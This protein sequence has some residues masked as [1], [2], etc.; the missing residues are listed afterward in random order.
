[1]G[2]LD[3]VQEG[4]LGLMKAVEKFDYSKGYRLSTYATWWVKQSIT[5]SLAD[6]S[7]TIRLPVHLV[8]AVN[9]IRRAQRLSLI[10]ILCEWTFPCRKERG[11]GGI[12]TY[13][14]LPSKGNLSLREYGPVSY[15]H[16]IKQGTSLCLSP[17]LGDTAARAGIPARR[18]G[19]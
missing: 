12:G 2:F 11:G 15:T 19:T 10:H 4:N 18:L 17:F 1:M 16:L 6:Q 13:P 8:E 14:L 3:L 5:R 7:R 9:K